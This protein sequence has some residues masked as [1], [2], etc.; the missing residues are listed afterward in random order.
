MELPTPPSPCEPRPVRIARRHRATV[1]RDIGK[2]MLT[3]AAQASSRQPFDQPRM[4]AIIAT[5]GTAY[6]HGKF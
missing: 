2:S 4:K 6:E 1:G 3:D 5:T